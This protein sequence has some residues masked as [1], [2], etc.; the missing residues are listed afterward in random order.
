MDDA[1]PKTGDVEA[2]GP[3]IDN[4]IIQARTAPGQRNILYEGERELAH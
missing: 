2:F 1:V 4:L 3:R